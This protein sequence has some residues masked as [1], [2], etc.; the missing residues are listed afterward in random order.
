MSRLKV[1]APGIE[2]ILDFFPAGVMALQTTR[3]GG[4]SAPPFDCLNLGTH[5]GDSPAAVAANRAY[6]AQHL[7][8]APRWLDQIHGTHVLDYSLA[9]PTDTA[10]DG[11]F[12][13]V[14]NQV[15]AVM[16]AD[17]LPVLIARQDG[18]QVGIAHAGWRGL[19]A[20]VIEQ[21]LSEMLA[22]D[23]QGSQQEWAFWLGPA[24][25]PQAFE[26]GNEV[27]LAFTAAD[28]RAAQAFTPSPSAASAATAASATNGKWLADLGLLAR[29]RIERFGQQQGL[30]GWR[31]E[32]HGECTVS[33]PEKYFS[34]RRD[35][36][37]GRMASLIYFRPI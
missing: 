36:K 4:V 26:V 37:T 7:P 9:A 2:Q 19:C 8:S 18:Q 10:A 5:V 28:A 20:G 34:Y 11:C 14:A 27:R 6:L 16:T 1:I 35:G 29:Q 12:S 17:C 22:A 23:P 24:I 30:P 15:C 13:G 3:A 25:G 31:I 21:T 32:E 33:T